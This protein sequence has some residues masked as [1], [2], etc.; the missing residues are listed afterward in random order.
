MADRSLEIYSYLSPT[1][2]GASLVAIGQAVSR[3]DALDRVLIGYHSFGPDGIVLASST[4]TL[5]PDVQVLIAHRPG[6][7]QPT[8]AARML[9][10]VNRI[11]DG[12]AD[13]H[14]V[15]GGAPGDQFREGDYL[16]HDD[17]YRRAGEYVDVLRKVWSADE[18]FSYEGEFYKFD[19]VR[20]P[21][22]KP[23][24]LRVH[25][26]GAS[27]AALD[28]GSAKSDVYML[29]GEPLNEV[30]DRVA[31]IEK[32]AAECGRLRPRISLSLRLYI[33]E[34]DERAWQIA[35]ADPAYQKWIAKGVS[36]TER[37]HAEDAG[38]NRQLALARAG[39]VHDDCLW[40]GIVGAMNGLG[41][42][43]ALVGT[44]DRVMETLKKYWDLGVDTFLLA[45]D[46][47][48]WQSSLAPS[49]VRM[50]QEFTGQRIRAIR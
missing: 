48:E 20:P 9:A 17:R 41:N 43:A 12:R 45:G 34:T 35:M 36:V 46:L 5:N 25:M 11:S 40:M 16:G 28:F 6:V 19:D 33:A 27:T 42:A 30:R 10:T 23:I 1:A 3:V 39:E 37:D 50:R 32:K 15:T 24:G 14:I 22:M 4:L 38:R 31:E 44:E 18:P 49:V 13:V 29:W 47:G 7:I 8:V 26:G 2:G 21:E